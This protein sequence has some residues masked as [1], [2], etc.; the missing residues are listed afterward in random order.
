M[1]SPYACFNSVGTTLDGC[2]C[3][4]DVQTPV[5]MAPYVSVTRQEIPADVRHTDDMYYIS[6]SDIF[7]GSSP[8]GKLP[9]GILYA[10]L[11]FP[12]EI[13]DTD[14]KELIDGWYETDSMP[15]RSP[16]IALGICTYKREE[17]LLRNV[18]S[19][20]DNIINNPDSPM[21]NRLEVYISDN[22]GTII[23]GMPSSEY[24]D[25]SLGKIC[26]RPYTCIF[27]QEHRWFRRFH[28]HH[29]RSC[30]Q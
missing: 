25:P 7:S 8:D 2:N 13:E 16:Y 3:F 9:A 14:V 15:V 30:S 28:P 18:H 10:E 27:Q 24:T 4:A 20:M 1:L 23:P 5:D 11:T 22:A 19:L 21:H 12:F 6:F 26:K 17:F 29:V